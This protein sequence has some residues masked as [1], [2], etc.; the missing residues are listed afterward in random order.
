MN[1]YKD[2]SIL[3]LPLSQPEEDIFVWTGKFQTLP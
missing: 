3:L 1:V 2:I